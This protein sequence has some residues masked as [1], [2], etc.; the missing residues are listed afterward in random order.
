MMAGFVAAM[1][2]QT[3]KIAY[4]GPLINAETAG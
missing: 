4:L 1:T 2:S 3:G